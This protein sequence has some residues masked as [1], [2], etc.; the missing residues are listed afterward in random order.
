MRYLFLLLFLVGSYANAQINK[1]NLKPFIGVQALFVYEI[2][3]DFVDAQTLERVDMPDDRISGLG[4]NA[5]LYLTNHIA[6][7]GYY[8]KESLL[9]RDI[10]YDAYAFGVTGVLNK[11]INTW[12][13]SLRFGGHIGDFSVPGFLLRAGLGFNFHLWK[14]LNVQTEVLYNYQTFNSNDVIPNNMSMRSLTIEGWG[15][16]VLVFI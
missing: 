2:G 4:L 12:A 14:F 6:L 1:G 5:G 3:E 7:V 15:L 10:E 9:N 8:G 13:A 16:S 11:D